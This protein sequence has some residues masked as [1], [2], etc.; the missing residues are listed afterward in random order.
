MALGVDMCVAVGYI[1][2][3]GRVV[4]LNGRHYEQD[5]GET[6]TCVQYCRYLIGSVS[7]VIVVVEWWDVTGV[8]FEGLAIGD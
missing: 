1:S 3:G 6:A 7:V 8:C 4:P 2:L 5:S